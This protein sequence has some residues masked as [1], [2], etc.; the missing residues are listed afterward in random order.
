MTTISNV[1]Y[2]N[3]LLT[4]YPLSLVLGYAY[5]QWTPAE[6]L[7]FDMLNNINVIDPCFNTL[8]DSFF[9][10]SCLINLDKP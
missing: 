10:F 4:M 8:I 9:N 5:F 3:R 6:W 1:E 2:M 7:M